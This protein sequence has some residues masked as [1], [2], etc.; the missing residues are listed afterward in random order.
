MTRHLGLNPMVTTGDPPWLRKPMTG[1]HPQLF[2]LQLRL[3]C[4]TSS[5]PTKTTKPPHICIKY[6]SNMYRICIKYIDHIY[7]RPQPP[8]SPSDDQLDAVVWGGPFMDPRDWMANRISDSS[9]A[10]FLPQAWPIPSRIRNTTQN[11]YCS[12]LKWIDPILNHDLVWGVFDII[13]KGLLYI[14]FPESQPLAT[15]PL[16]VGPKRNPQVLHDP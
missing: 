15:G 12:P 7:Q 1:R 4:F 3:K 10:Q 14:S 9:S 16:V 11:D 6:V 13:G 2:L 8:R 5:R